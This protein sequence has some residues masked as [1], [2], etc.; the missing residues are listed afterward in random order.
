[1][2][3]NI[4]LEQY[5]EYHDIMYQIKEKAVFEDEIKTYFKNRHLGIEGDKLPWHKLDQLVGLRHSELTIWAGENGSGKS[6]ILGQLKLSL[7]KANKTVLTASLEMTPAK[8]LS[9]MVRQAIGSLNVTNRDVEEFMNWRK[10]KAFLFDH[11][12]RIEPWQAMALCRYAKQHLKCDHI[13]LDSMMKLVRG[14]DDFNGQKDLVDALC[15]VAKETK[16][17][18]HLVHHIRKGGESSR[19]AEKK[20]IKGSGVITDLADNVMIIARNRLKEKET[21]Q[22]RIVDNTQPDTFLIT[23]KQRNGDWEGTLGLWFDKKS[24]QFT[25]IFQQ[26]II[27]YLGEE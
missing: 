27:N 22:N 5:R 10:D 25:E 1:M 11:Q 19:I 9:R 3:I 4:D 16:M 21:E 14:E 12:G 26:P 18:I 2:L 23:A 17:H 20:D 7:L 15:D 6:L 24:Q 13:I 8:T